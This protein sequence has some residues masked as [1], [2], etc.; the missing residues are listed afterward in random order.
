MIIFCR[1]DPS[2]TKFSWSNG[3]VYNQT[4]DLAFVSGK[5]TAQILGWGAGY[6][7]QCPVEWAS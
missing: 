3:T 4:I 5:T 1:V 2:A 7:A 6:G